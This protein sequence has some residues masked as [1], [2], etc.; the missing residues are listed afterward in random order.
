MLPHLVVRSLRAGPDVLNE[1]VQN[2]VVD[3]LAG[4]QRRHVLAR[5]LPPDAAKLSAHAPRSH[6]NNPASLHDICI[7][8]TLIYIDR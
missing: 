6:D 3:I 4:Q 5:H 7:Y 8:T 2:A 1:G